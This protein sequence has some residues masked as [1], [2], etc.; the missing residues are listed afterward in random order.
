METRKE[1]IIQS[2]VEAIGRIS[3]YLDDETNTRDDK[4]ELLDEVGW[5]IGE[6]ESIGNGE[7]DRLGIDF[8]L[9]IR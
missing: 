9:M 7:N 4:L 2:L 6:L 8:G 5:A 3:D 1:H